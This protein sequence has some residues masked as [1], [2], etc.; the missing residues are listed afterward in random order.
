MTLSALIK[1]HG[2]WAKEEKTEASDWE[3][4]INWWLDHIGENDPLLRNT[5]LDQCRRDAE[6]RKYFMEH[7]ILERRKD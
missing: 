3:K 7:A 5:T 4:L 2:D 6:A 1:K